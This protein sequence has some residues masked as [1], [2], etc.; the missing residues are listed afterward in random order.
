M[1]SK[2]TSKYQ[3][4]IP[5]AVRSRLKLSVKDGLEWHFSEGCV[6]VAAAKKPFLAYRGVV[7]VGKGD[8]R[9]DIEEARRAAV[10][11]YG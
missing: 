3:V 5:K 4:T 8:I 2:I 1:Q 11:K 7:R 6:T 9:K 10:I